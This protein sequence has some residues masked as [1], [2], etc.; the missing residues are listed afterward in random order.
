M[1]DETLNQEEQSTT[2]TPENEG[3]KEDITQQPT[4]ESAQKESNQSEADDIE[5]AA[6]EHGWRPKEEFGDD[7]KWVNAK[8]FMYRRDLLDKLHNQNRMMK[9]MTEKVETYKKSIDNVEKIILQR[10]ELARKSE[11]EVIL[12]ERR[13]AI[14]NGD[15]EAVERLDEK[16]SH[17]KETPPPKNEP[18]IAPEVQDWVE[19]NSH[20]FNSKSEENKEMAEYATWVE[21]SLK[22]NN[23][24]ISYEESLRHVDKE[25]RQRY[26]HRFRNPNLERKPAVESSNEYAPGKKSN[27]DRGKITAEMHQIAEKFVAKGLYKS[28]DEYF[29]EILQG[30]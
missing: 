2:L 8:E 13:E 27:F 14:Q 21:R 11:R 20:W 25:I 4:E 19:K 9:K 22:R 5:K 26:P 18:D 30:N 17:L 29:K 28:K 12:R 7:D 6:R 16:M 15:V 10:E 3:L 23:P 1:L 24:D